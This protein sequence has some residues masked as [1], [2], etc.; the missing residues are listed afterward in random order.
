[1]NY[2]IPYR[3]ITRINR[4][5]SISLVIL[6]GIL[7]SACSSMMMPKDN[8]RCNSFR[9]EGL[10][11][12][13]ALPFSVKYV[14]KYFSLNWCAPDSLKN[15][16]AS[17]ADLISNLSKRNPEGEELVTIAFTGDIMW[18]RNGWNTF[19]D[20]RLTERLSSIDMLFGNLE[21]PVDTLSGV[22]S[23]LPDYVRYNAHPGLI[24]SFRRSDGSNIFTALSLANNHAFDRGAAGLAGTHA[25]LQ[26]EG[27]IA[28]GAALPGD[29]VPGYAVA[30][31]KGLR[32]GFYAAGWGMN[33]PELIENGKLEMNILPGIAPLNEEETDISEIVSILTKMDSDS[34]DFKVLFMHWGYEYEMYPDVAIVRLARRLAEAGA[35]MIIGSHP[36]VIQPAEIWETP[37]KADDSGTA[38]HRTL[39]AYSLGNLTTTMYSPAHRLGM[40]LPVTICRSNDSGEPAWHVGKPLFVY[41]HVRGLAG[42]KRRLMLYDDY[43][44]EMQLRS[45]RKAR[46]IANRLEPVFNIAF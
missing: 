34:V 5:T 12:K 4:R 29:S 14:R 22:P 13:E 24:R 32:I 1:M 18:I 26:N 6:A 41:N 8:S 46:R 17:Q 25:F 19:A 7:V 16:F 27:I 45:N 11:L 20:A 2:L 28:T 30:E 39:I 15:H 37:A 44:G 35:D 10:S 38:V 31:S 36:H 42:K 40:V 33:K 9:P 3:I 43:I 23:L 21:T